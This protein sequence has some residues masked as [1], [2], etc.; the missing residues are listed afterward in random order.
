MLMYHS[1]L[2]MWYMKILKYNHIYKL[3]D[4]DNKISLLKLKF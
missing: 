1:L 4:K 2:K 3:L